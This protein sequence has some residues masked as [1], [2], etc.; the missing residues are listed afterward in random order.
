MKIE[1]GDGKS[2]Y[3]VVLDKIGA[4]SATPQA[5]VDALPGTESCYAVYDH[6]YTLADGRPK[7]K[8]YFF[9]WAHHRS[10]PH[11]KMLY[12]SQKSV[13]VTSLEGVEE[14]TLKSE[15]DALIALGA[16]EEEA[17]EQPWDPDDD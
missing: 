17:E 11:S 2:G 14:C 15:E 3:K 7:S 5:F 8:L 9:V 10:N 4:R 12:T 6:E 13:L 16:A 1:E